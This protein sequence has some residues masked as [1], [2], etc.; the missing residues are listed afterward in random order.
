MKL[1][2]VKNCS[3]C[4]FGSLFI[5]LISAVISY[6]VFGILFL[7]QDY[8]IWRDCEGSNLWP[9]VLVSINL[10][11]LRTNYKENKEINSIRLVFLLL[12]EL[13]LGIWGCIELSD[14][15]ES[16]LTL[17]NSNL[18][19]FGLATC[20]LQF[21][22]FI[23]IVIMFIVLRINNNIDTNRLSSTHAGNI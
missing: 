19:R 5:I 12:I 10:C 21:S 13:G 17:K 2:N 14:K 6:I 8:S 1:E 18:W 11:L 23:V 9:Y 7:V 22:I 3:I 4:L 20:I 16:C 15:C